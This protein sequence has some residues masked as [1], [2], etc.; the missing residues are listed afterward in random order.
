[1]LGHQNQSFA[2]GSL[3]I[4]VLT[5][6]ISCRGV[7]ADSEECRGTWVGPTDCALE[8]WL[9]I[10][11][12]AQL[13]VDT[14]RSARGGVAPHGGGILPDYLSEVAPALELARVWVVVTPLA[15]VLFE[16]VVVETVGNDAGNIA[17]CNTV[18][19]VLAISSTAWFTS[20][21]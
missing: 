12:V 11:W 13:R 7:V 5:G 2:F 9:S 10:R 17:R 4:A 16:L 3:D 6:D 18:G 8:V 1:V 20:K 15:A 19:Y 21:C 14:C